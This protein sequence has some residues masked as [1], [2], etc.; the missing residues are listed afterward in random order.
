[1]EKNFNE[2]INDVICKAI[3]HYKYLQDES[4]FIE[5]NVDDYGY[6]FVCVNWDNYMDGFIRFDRVKQICKFLAKRL[7]KS[8]AIYTAI[9]VFREAA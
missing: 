9:G 1:M 3:N 5:H 4:V 6:G 2:L 7:P 8:T